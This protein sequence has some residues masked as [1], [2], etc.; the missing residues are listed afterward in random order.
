[1]NNR[2]T[3][4]RVS[5]DVVNNGTITFYND[6]IAYSAGSGSDSAAPEAVR[7]NKMVFR[8]IMQLAEKLR[9]ANDQGNACV[10]VDSGEDDIKEENMFAL[11]P[12]AAKELMDERGKQ[13]GHTEMRY[14]Q[15]Q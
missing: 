12:V 5:S 8:R 11:I 3:E 2:L 4:L 13:G 6:A 9:S 14:N 1:M 10:S 7:K 15:L